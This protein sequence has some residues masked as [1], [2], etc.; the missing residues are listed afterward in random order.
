MLPCP[1]L[2]ALIIAYVT[3][4]TQQVSLVFYKNTVSY[5][6]SVIIMINLKLHENL[7]H[8]KH[9]PHVLLLLPQGDHFWVFQEMVEL[10]YQ[11]C[12]FFISMCFW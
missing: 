1:S 10:L 2:L 3:F 7:Q 6:Q 11:S 12:H 5:S 9:F 4:L 8:F